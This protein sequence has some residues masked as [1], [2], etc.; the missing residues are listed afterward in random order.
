MGNLHCM[1][2]SSLVLEYSHVCMP[3]TVD[4]D[5]CWPASR[6]RFAYRPVVVVGFIPTVFVC[7]RVTTSCVA[8]P[9]GRFDFC[10][11][12]CCMPTA[13]GKTAA[14]QT[15]YMV[16]PTVNDVTIPNARLVA[17]LF[18][19]EPE[20]GDDGE[21]ASHQQQQTAAHLSSAPPT[22]EGVTGEPVLCRRGQQVLSS[23]T[24]VYDYTSPIVRSARNIL[25][26]AAAATQRM[27]KIG[28]GA[29]A[30]T[31]GDGTHR[32]GDEDGEKCDDNHEDADATAVVGDGVGDSP[33]VVVDVADADAD[34][35]DVTTNA[36]REQQE[37]EETASARVV[38][39][40]EVEMVSLK[41][42]K[43]DDEGNGNATGAVAAS[44]AA[45][46]TAAPATTTSSPLQDT[47]LEEKEQ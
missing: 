19:E 4:P 47:T 34:D 10:C 43:D 2:S 16:A 17:T 1:Y 20:T 30:G 5:C 15:M 32:D 39:A 21:E 14:G 44:V 13:Q 42:K 8:Y 29:A 3:F 40:G 27:R 28:A 26:D 45:A 18:Q 22:E 37:E 12:C 35:D 7:T 38:P 25:L 36:A 9:A 31:R 24:F 23:A 46:A 11:C 6:R 33:T 41:G